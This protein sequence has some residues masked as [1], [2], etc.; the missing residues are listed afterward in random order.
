MS[1]ECVCVLLLYSS[2]HRL[3]VQVGRRTDSITT[4]DNNR[5]DN[6]YNIDRATVEVLL[7]QERLIED[8]PVSSSSPQQLPR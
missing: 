8:H 1:R 7:S 6:P 4:D 3:R 2:F 5:E